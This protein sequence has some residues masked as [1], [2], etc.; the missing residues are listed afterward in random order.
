MPQCRS[1]WMKPCL[2]SETV[3]DMDVSKLAGH[4]AAYK[5]HWDK[6]VQE[7]VVNRDWAFERYAYTSTDTPRDGGPAVVDTGWGLVIHHHNAD[8][9]WRVARNAWGSDQPLPGNQ[10]SRQAGKQTKCRSG[11]S[12][13]LLLRL[14][15]L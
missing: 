6:P 14:R 5:T 13:E 7:C 2:P 1:S 4:V 9:K 12:C 15:L 8:G 3:I 10:A 11:F